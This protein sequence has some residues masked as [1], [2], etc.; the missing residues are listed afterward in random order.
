M[1]RA[2]LGSATG[3]ERARLANLVTLVVA[4]AG[5]CIFLDGPFFWL[6]VLVCVG[7]AAYGAF[8]VFLELD[9]RGVPIE[10]LATPAAAAFAT[11]GISR[12]AGPSVAGLVCLALGGIL[13]SVSVLLESRL[14]GP[15]DPA[16]QRRQQQLILLSVFLGFLCFTGVAGAVD[17]GLGEAPLRP[18]ASAEATFIL[19][20]VADAVIAFV[21]GY[22]LAAFRS[23]SVRQAAWS[24]GTYAV[25][26]AVAAGFV[27]AIALPRLLGPALLAA[28]FY[29]WSAY[30][31]SSRAERRSSAWLTEY[32]ALAGAAVLAVAWNLLLR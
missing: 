27:R 17:G 26:I 9:P 19:L 14:L 32:A 7:A 29:L 18:I 15:A 23:A 25:V 6:G 24:A 21:L 10:S 30:R 5:I 12:L 8:S 13:V 4:V 2:R 31:T 20:V 3:G 16:R 22:R 1:S 28:V 11:I